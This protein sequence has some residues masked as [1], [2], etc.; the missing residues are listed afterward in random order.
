MAKTITAMLICIAAADAA[1]CA[2]VADHGRR[3]GTVSRPT[4]RGGGVKAEAEA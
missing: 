4:G 1:I 2:A 3:A